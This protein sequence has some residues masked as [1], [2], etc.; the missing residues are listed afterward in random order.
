M[1][2]TKGRLKCDF[3]GE[4]D[5]ATSALH[6]KATNGLWRL[7]RL[8][9]LLLLLLLRGPQARDQVKNDPGFQ[10]LSMDNGKQRPETVSGTMWV[11]FDYLA[12]CMLPISALQT[13]A[14]IE[15]GA[16]PRLLSEGF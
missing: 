14:E 11:R 10:L 13:E 3:A 12:M 6:K 2:V 9:L 8:L 1:S 15:H 4:A 16:I 7:R 5:D